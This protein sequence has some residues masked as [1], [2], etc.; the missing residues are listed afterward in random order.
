ML[1]HYSIAA[2]IGRQRREQIAANV[3]ACRQPK[4]TNRRTPATRM[5]LDADGHA[6]TST[7]P[8]MTDRW[9][10]RGWKTV[11]APL[12]VSAFLLAGCH[13]G[14]PSVQTSTPPNGGPLPQSVPAPAP[15]APDASQPLPQD[16]TSPAENPAAPDAP[17]PEDPNLDAP[18]PDQQGVPPDSP[19]PAD[20]ML[21]GPHSCDSPLAADLFMWCGGP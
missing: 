1:T 18:A 20:P 12:A 19:S 14:S 16:T 17:Q 21:V 6:S 9:L 15:Q 3:A 13:H 10:S 11:A 7:A 4:S 8:S 5:A 2:E